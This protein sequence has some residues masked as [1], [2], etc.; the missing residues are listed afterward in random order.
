MEAVAAVGF[1]SS[2]LT[3]IDFTCHVLEIGSQI[4]RPGLP[5]SQLTLEQVSKQIKEHA[6][7]VKP[8]DGEQRPFNEGDQVRNASNHSYNI[9]IP[10]GSW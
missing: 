8:P 5:A 3:F 2:I 1:A 7:L 10:L 9:L 6:K 4:R